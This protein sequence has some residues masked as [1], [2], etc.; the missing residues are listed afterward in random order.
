MTKSKRT[1]SIIHGWRLI[2]L[3]TSWTYTELMYRNIV[4]ILCRLTTSVL[5]NWWWLKIHTQCTNILQ[6]GFPHAKNSKCIPTRITTQEGRR[7]CAR[8]MR[9][10]ESKSKRSVKNGCMRC[11]CMEDLCFDGRWQHTPAPKK[12]SP[13]PKKQNTGLHTHISFSHD[14]HIHFAFSLHK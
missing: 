7:G 14:T 2:T 12:R 6:S 1:G 13:N 10:S 11:V 9:S 4:V 3:V 8:S 5:C